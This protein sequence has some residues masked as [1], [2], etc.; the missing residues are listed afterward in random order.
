MIL[1]YHIFYIHVNMY[2]GTLNV[3]IKEKPV[4]N[5]Q[6]IHLWLTREI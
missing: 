3:T 1:K 2:K 6:T 5:L 4:L